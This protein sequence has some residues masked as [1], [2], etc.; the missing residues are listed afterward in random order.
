MSLPEISSRV[1]GSIPAWIRFIVVGFAIAGSYYKI[2]QVII[3]HDGRMNRHW[4][5]NDISGQIQPDLREVW[6]RMNRI[7]TRL[8]YLTSRIERDED[9]V[10]AMKTILIERGPIIKNLQD[11]MDD[12][13]DRVRILES[14]KR[15]NPL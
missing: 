3:E 6:E 8:D 12:M 7:D 14:G 11:R 10:A 9:N 2:D 1:L 5:V 4:G 13:E 15:R